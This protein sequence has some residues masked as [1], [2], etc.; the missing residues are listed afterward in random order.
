M[1]LL[2]VV[3]HLPPSPSPGQSVSGDCYATCLERRDKEERIARALA[4]YA[5]QQRLE[6][7]TEGNS[8]ETF[9]MCLNVLDSD[10]IDSGTIKYCTWCGPDFNCLSR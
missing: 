9:N 10:E 6:G 4:Y 5:E 1:K 7:L 2:T 8:S 3:L